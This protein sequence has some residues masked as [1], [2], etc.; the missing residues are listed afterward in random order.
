MGPQEIRAQCLAIENLAA[1][2]HV[3][4]FGLRDLDNLKFLTWLKSLRNR[5]QRCC[6]KHMH[7]FVGK[8]WR[9]VE[10]AE[11][12]D[13]SRGV[14]RL[15]LEFTRGGKNRRFA[16]FKFAR[17]KLEKPLRD[18][19]S[20]IAHQYEHAI[21]A[22]RD[23]SYCARMTDDVADCFVHNS[24]TGRGDDMTLHPKHGADMGDSH[25][26]IG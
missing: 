17:T 23:N 15:F 12:F 18:G 24:I 1:R 2:N 22:Q 13:L 20:A 8:S 3:R 9:C 19:N 16:A 14:T 25:G 11:R 5:T 7:E 10:R 4:E 26:R 21:I 6:E